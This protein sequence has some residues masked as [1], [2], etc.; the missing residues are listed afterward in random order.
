M[1]V[2]IVVG[3]GANKNILT[4]SEIANENKDLEVKIAK[5]DEELIAAFK[6]K[7]IDV[8]VRGSLNSSN[9]IKS[10]KELTNLHT[11]DAPIISRASYIK[12]EN[13]GKKGYEFLIGPVGIDEGNTIAERVEL[14]VESAKF[15]KKLGKTPKIAILAG[16]RKEDLGRNE[17]IDKSIKD[18]E[19][20][21]IMVEK[22]LS[23]QEFKF[24]I[25][26]Y[27]ILIEK[28]IKDKNNII[29]APDGISG[30]LIFRSLVLLNFCPSYGAITFG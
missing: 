5:S 1:T 7:T 28:S 6:D 10:I 17:T 11:N 21:A 19:E 25:K 8:V 23:K 14:G 30:N 3:F 22:E 26:N 9:I 16:G 29:I 4:A 27:Y 18:S 13:E 20:I 15:M 12:K 24:S 2:K